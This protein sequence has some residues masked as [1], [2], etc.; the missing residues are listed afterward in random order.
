MRRNWLIAAGAVALV[1]LAWLVWHSFRRPVERAAASIAESQSSIPVETT[2]PIENTAG[3]S[4]DAA[5][6]A[7]TRGA[8]TLSHT[9]SEPVIMDR[10]RATLGKGMPQ[11]TLEVAGELERVYPEGAM[12]EERSLY[13][14]DALIALNRIPQM[15][16]AARRHLEKWPGTPTSVRVMARTGVHPELRPP[17]AYQ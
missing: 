17:S 1:A 15:R 12:A 14:I 11:T 2:D 6:A 16:D 3:S 10:L 9:P 8:E 5:V 4:S 7:N 13:I